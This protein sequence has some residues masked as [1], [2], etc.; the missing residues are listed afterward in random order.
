[1]RWNRLSAEGGEEH[2]MLPEELDIPCG[3]LD[4]TLPG[5][6]FFAGVRKR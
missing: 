5:D 3:T 6:E 1:M 4:R 2:G